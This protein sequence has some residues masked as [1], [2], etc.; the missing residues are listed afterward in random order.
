MILGKSEGS[1]LKTF[2]PFYLHGHHKFNST[3]ENMC[4]QKPFATYDCKIGYS[5]NECH[6]SA[7][8]MGQQILESVAISSNGKLSS[9]S[10]T[11]Y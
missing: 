3:V 4:A 5:C 7:K 9:G 2:R 8:G 11:L 6:S 10:E 1:L